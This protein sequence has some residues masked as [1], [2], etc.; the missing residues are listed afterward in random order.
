MSTRKN[1]NNTNAPEDTRMQRDRM[2]TQRDSEQQKRVGEL[3]MISATDT[4]DKADGVWDGQTGELIEGGLTEEQLE[5]L[6]ASHIGEMAGEDEIIRPADSMRPPLGS[7]DLPM[8][9]GPNGTPIALDEPEPDEI[10]PAIPDLPRVGAGERPARQVQVLD[11]AA[12]TRV[13][14]VNADIDPTIGQGPQSQW[15]F[16]KGKRYEVPLHVAHHLS[17][18][19]YVS[20]GM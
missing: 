16:L 17:E 4:A 1:P 11:R 9:I 14:R 2:A 3:S 10:T 6:E 15:H 5:A 19:G 13:V 7:A 8:G 12:A 18:K 20:S